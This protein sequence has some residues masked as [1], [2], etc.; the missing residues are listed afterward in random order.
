M[1][2][3]SLLALLFAVVFTATAQSSTPMPIVAGD[4]IVNTGTVTKQLPKLTGGYAGT[5]I[6]TD[7]TKISGT[8]AGTVQLQSSGNNVTW[9]NEGSAFTI[10]NVTLQTA[11]FSI[12]A[13]LP[14]YLRL[15]FTGSGTESVG[16]QTWYVNRK[17]MT[18]LS[19]N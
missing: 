6:Y 10:T 19:T 8:G 14:V 13:P 16:T 15:L 2:S 3:F 7:L 18:T 1:K 12:A 4:T 11:K 9:V 5:A 17:Y